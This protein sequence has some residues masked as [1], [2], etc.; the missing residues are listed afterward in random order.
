VDV[1]DRKSGPS[2]SLRTNSSS[3]AGISVSSANGVS[4]SNSLF[5]FERIGIGGPSEEQFGIGVQNSI[6]PMSTSNFCPGKQALPDPFRLVEDGR[7][8]DDA[9]MNYRTLRPEG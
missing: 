2:G 9:I 5:F 1:G 8:T 4:S 6:P 3:L 7:S